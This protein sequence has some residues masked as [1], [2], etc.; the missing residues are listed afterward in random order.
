[1]E[2]LFKIHENEVYVR[3]ETMYEVIMTGCKLPGINRRET[4]KTKQELK[5]VGRLFEKN[6]ERAKQLVA[7][8]IFGISTHNMPVCIVTISAFVYYSKKHGLDAGP[9]IDAI[10]ANEDWLYKNHGDNMYNYL[11]R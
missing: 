10:D 9:L 4:R 7:K 2:E 1:M 3:A 5:W 11:N 8:L 6:L